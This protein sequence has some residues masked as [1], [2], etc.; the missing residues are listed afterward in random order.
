MSTAPL[1]WMGTAAMSPLR[2][3]EGLQAERT[4]L[5]WTRMSLAALMNGGLFL[6]HAAGPVQYAAVASALVAI[7]VIQIVAVRR[8]RVLARRP[9]PE[10]IGACGPIVGV[11]VAISALIVAGMVTI[12]A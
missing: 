6:A 12:L 3:A 11:A 9:L 10:P 1:G 2:W 7:L 4:E 8:Q 5:S